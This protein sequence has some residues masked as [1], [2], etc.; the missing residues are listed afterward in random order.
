MNPAYTSGGAGPTPTRPDARPDPD[1]TPDLI[2]TW[3]KKREARRPPCRVLESDELRGESAEFSGL[4][5]ILIGL[6]E[7]RRGIGDLEIVDHFFAIG[8]AIFP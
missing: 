6:D 8:V 3:H 2:P 1:P 7:F 4:K 5:L